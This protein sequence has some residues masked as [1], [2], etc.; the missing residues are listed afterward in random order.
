MSD[1]THDAFRPLLAQLQADMRSMRSDMRCMRLG[2]TVLR[3]NLRTFISVRHAMTETMIEGLL[4][5]GHRRPRVAF[6]SVRRQALLRHDRRVVA[7][8]RVQ[9]RRDL[10]PR[11]GRVELL[12]DVR[13]G[14]IANA[15]SY[16]SRQEMRCADGSLP[17]HFHHQLC[18]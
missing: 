7:Q 10:S 17:G 2:Q 16:F 5:G 15:G 14:Q 4:G 13:Y 8:I 3:E 18:R 12:R 1:T 9:V 6:L 11:T